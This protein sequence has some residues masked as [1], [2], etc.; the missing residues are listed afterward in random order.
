MTEKY[1]AIPYL[2]FDPLV[3]FKGTDEDINAAENEEKSIIA[4][5]ENLLQD[6]RFL[7]FQYDEKRD[8]DIQT[9]FCSKSFINDNGWRLSYL[10]SVFGPVMHEEYTA[11][12]SN[13]RNF[14]AMFRHMLKHKAGN[15]E[16]YT[17]KVLYS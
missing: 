11:D 1:I 7:A 3:Y 9:I 12:G 14:N 4:I 15:D 17:I 5:Y 6:P 10:S 16:N 13:D 8:N 2:T